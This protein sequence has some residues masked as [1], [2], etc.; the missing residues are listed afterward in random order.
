MESNAINSRE[1]LDAISD[2]EKHAQFMKMLEGSI[3]RI[4][5]D[6]AAKK[7]VVVEDV[8]TIE[9]FGFTRE[10][11]PDAQPQEFPEWRDDPEPMQA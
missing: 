11:F 9:K 4:E 2:T 8:S 10:D 6:N 3:F 7:W 1:D 5:K